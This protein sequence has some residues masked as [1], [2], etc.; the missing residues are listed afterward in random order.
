M[1]KLKRFLAGLAL[2]KL[3]VFAPSALAQGI[4]N[5]SIALP[6]LFS[7]G[8]AFASTGT[9]VQTLYTNNVP[10]NVLQ[11]LSSVG[12]LHQAIFI[13][14]YGHVVNNADAKS[15]TITFGGVT[16]DSIPITA[17]TANA[18]EF[19]CVIHFRTAGPGAGA[20][21]YSCLGTQGPGTPTTA[22]NQIGGSGVAATVSVDPTTALAVA[23]KQVI[24]ATTGDV[25]QDGIF[26][27]VVQ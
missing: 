18:F 9:G 21:P 6:A 17:S 23:T 24:G 12:T 8:T 10:A 25:I 3:L 15:V 26:V 1:N 27:S 13:Y 19:E 11:S 5:P 20:Q 4:V 16:L 7:S 22:I 2:L 14:V